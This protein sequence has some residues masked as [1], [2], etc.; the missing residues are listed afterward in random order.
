[1]LFNTT[2]VQLGRRVLGEELTQ[3]GLVGELREPLPDLLLD[4]RRHGHLD[5]RAIRRSLQLVPGEQR[6]LALQMKNWLMVMHYIMG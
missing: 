1:M 4:E 3:L 2:V 6:W 5:R